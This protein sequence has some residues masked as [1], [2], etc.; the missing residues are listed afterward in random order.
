MEKKVRATARVKLVL[1]VVLPD[2]WG[3]DCSVSQAH[4]Q[5][6]DSALNIISQKI[7]G[8]GRDIQ[9]IGEPESVVIIAE[10]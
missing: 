4:K 9:I 8:S 1:E 5:A 2:R 7:A 10:E 3:G 6:K